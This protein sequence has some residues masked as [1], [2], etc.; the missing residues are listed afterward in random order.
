VRYGNARVGELVGVDT[1]GIVGQMTQEVFALMAPNL[2]H[3]EAA[4]VAW[5]KALTRLDER[6]SFELCIAGA[7][8]R[9]LLLQLFP[10]A[11]ARNP[12]DGVGVVLRDVTLER[13]LARAKDELVSVVS[14]ELRTPL[15]SL[16]GFAELLLDRDSAEQQRRQYL[17]V[18]LQEG[19]RLTALINDFLDLQRMESGRQSVAPVPTDLRT[20]LTQ[21][22][23]A[24]GDYPERPIALTVEDNLPLALADPGRIQQVVANLLSNARKYSPAGGAVEVSAR[25]DNGAVV[26]TVQDHG[27]GIPKDA[28]PCLFEKFYRVDN[29]DR[30]A[31]KGTGLGLAVVK[32]LV[33][34]HGGRAW[35]ESDGPGEGSRFAFTLPCAAESA[36]HG[37]VLVVEDDPGF[38]RLLEAELSAHGYTSVRVPSGEAAL[39]QLTAAQPRV[40]LLD[41]MLPGM[42]GEVFLRRLRM[43]GDTD[44]PVV[45]VTVKDLDAAARAA[46]TA[47]GV[48]AIL[49]KGP[50][51]A[52]A[53]QRA[54]AEALAGPVAVPA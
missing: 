38:A 25:P 12:G 23:D 26:V 45:V 48:T 34:S 17:T 2:Q 40:V 24:A 29:S 15:A 41:L 42:Q 31:I 51:I 19:R 43:V 14:H 22:V 32:Q 47:Q 16:V 28:L 20:L 11:D 4:R 6:P 50:G 10:V 33:E 35:A 3:P 9:D 21:A 5:R 30:R 13:D 46:L 44:V 37:D 8:P 49:T 18:M 54:V 36:L 52:V 27:L 7:P 39:A 1:S 53:V